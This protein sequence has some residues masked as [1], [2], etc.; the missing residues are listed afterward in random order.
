MSVLERPTVFV[1]IETTGLNYVR[2]RVIEVAA[3]R[4][5]GGQVVREFNQLIDPETELPAF[6]TSLTGIRSSDLRSAPTFSQIAD[7]LYDI[8][9]G[10]VFVAH[11]VRFDYSFLKQEFKRTG[12][13]FSP[14]QLCTM[15]LSRALYPEHKSHKL[16]SL[17]ERHGF[18]FEARHRAYDDAA[19][20]WQFLQLVQREFEAEILATAI[21]K[22][23]K[24]PSMPK[25]LDPLQ[26]AG[27]PE[28]PGVYIFEDEASRPLYVGKSVNIK[29]RVQSHFSRDHEAVGEF[30]IS[31]GVRNISTQTTPDELQALLLES[32]LVKQLQPLYNKQLRRTS[33][34]TIVRQATTP[35]GYLAVKLEEA[36]GIDVEGLADILAVYPRRSQARESLEQVMKDFRLCPKLCGVEKSK[37][38][39]FWHQLRKCDGACVGAEPANTYNQRLLDAFSRRRMQAWPYTS[40][41]LI[42]DRALETQGGVVVDQWCVVAEV[43]QEP[44]CAPVIRTFERAFDL[45][46]YK[47]LQ[48]HLTHKLQQ[49]RIQPITLE[50][51]QQ[52]ISTV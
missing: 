27:L 47:I 15:R 4:I 38:A 50:Q 14:K 16:A 11:N 1:D 30:K 19:V 41:V 8:L 26:V 32:R 51:L 2:G 49:L 21:A 35:E 24:Q 12:R 10:A 13:D 25:A 22:Q 7:E 46:T 20:L 37:N 45:D 5:E 40:P 33:K 28:G 31:Q 52:M 3:I 39:C 34:L 29:K 9:D 36:N 17:I 44:Y 23:L 42:S 43:T 6:T 48:S 18:S